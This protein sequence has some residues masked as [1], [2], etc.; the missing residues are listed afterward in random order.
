MLVSA[1]F[2]GFFIKGLEMT[3]K[4]LVYCGNCKG[5]GEGFYNGAV[6][7]VCKGLGEVWADVEVEEDEEFEVEEEYEDP[8]DYVGMGWV[9]DRGR[10]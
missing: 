10:P 5:S 3:D 8:N 7:Y 9:D 1:Y 6:C 2:E 4:E